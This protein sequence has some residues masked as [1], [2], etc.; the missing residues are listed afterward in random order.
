MSLTAQLPKTYTL[1]WK[2]GFTHHDK[3]KLS[4]PMELGKT[5][6]DTYGFMLE[7]PA[8][9]DLLKVEFAKSWVTFEFIEVNPCTDPEDMF[10]AKVRAIT[11]EMKPQ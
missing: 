9:G 3:P 2:L 8:V 1:G 6:L 11:R 10:F 4:Q 5:V 7:K